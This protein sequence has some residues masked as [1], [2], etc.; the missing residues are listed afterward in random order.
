MKHTWKRLLSVLLALVMVIGLIAVPAMADEETGKKPSF[1]WEEVENARRL[2]PYRTE[3]KPA[4]EPLY[5]DSDVV[6]VSIVFDEKPAI[7]VFSTKEI[8]EDEAAM[9]YSDGLRAKQESMVE[10][11]SRKALKGQELDVVWNL[12]LIA[13]LV[14][15]N[16]PYG[17][18]DAIKSVEGV[19]DVYIETRYE[20]ATAETADEPNQSIAT[21][22]TGATEVWSDYTG[23]GS[24]IAI[25]DTGLDTDHEL[26]DPNAFIKA[27]SEK[28]DVDLLT[29]GE[30]SS[31]WSRLH[32]A[33]RSSGRGAQ[34]Y[35]NTKV[36]FGFNYVDSDFDITHDNDSAGEHGSHVAGIAAA[37]R[38]VKVSGKYVSAVEN[39]LTQGVAPDAQLLIMKVFGKGGGAYDSDYMVAIEDAIVLGADSVNLSLG[40]GAPGFATSSTPAYQEIMDNLATCD[41]TVTISMGNSGSWA[42]S[43]Y[44]EVPYAGDGNFYTGGSPGSYAN[45]FTVASVDNIGQTGPTLEASGTKFAYYESDGYGNELIATI[46][47]EHDFIYIDSAGT[48]NEFA[49]AAAAGL[50]SGKI[51]VCNRGGDISFYVKANA[52]AANGAAAVIVA[53]NQDG[54]IHMN[55]TGYEYTIPAITITQAD[56]ALLKEGESGTLTIGEGDEAYEVTYY[57]GKITVCDGVSAIV[58]DPGYYTMSDFSSWGVPGNLT[59]KPEITAPGGSIYSVNGA[60]AGGK[61]YEIMS[62]TSM[63]A[64]QVTGLAALVA[65]YIRENNLTSKTGKSERFLVQSLLMS[66]AEPLFDSEDNYYSV[67]KQGSGLARVDR[68]VTARSYIEMD[69]DA[70]ASAAD[71]KVKVELGD[72]PDR[73]GT[74]SFKFTINNFSNED[75]TYDLSADFFTQYVYGGRFVL[76]DTVIIPVEIEYKID[77]EV[78]SRDAY[79]DFLWDF[80]GDDEISALDAQVILDYVVKGTDIPNHADSADVDEDGKITT[81]DAY[82]V[83]SYVGGADLT[84]PAGGKKEVEV[85]FWIIDTFDYNGSFIEGYVYA[86][87]QPTASEKEEGIEATEVHSIPVLGYYGSWMEPRMLELDNN[88]YYI[89]VGQR[90][91]SIGY[92]ND[93]YAKLPGGD[94][95]TV[96]GN[97]FVEDD[98]Y[99]PERDSVSS[100]SVISSVQYTAI[101]NYGQSRLTIAQNGTTK[102]DAQLGSGYGAYYYVNGGSWQNRSTAK[103]INYSLANFAED[104]QLVLTFAIAPE[105]YV[106]GGAVD[107]DAI[108]EAAASAACYMVA[109]VATVDNT[110]PVINGEQI[111]PVYGTDSDALAG[112]SIPVSDNRYV[113]AVV[114]C[115]EAYYNGDEEG[116]FARTGSDADAELGAESAFDFEVDSES[117][118]FFIQAYD[119][120][121]NMTTY[122]L[123]LNWEE[124]QD[125]EIS[126]TL[127]EIEAAIINYGEVQLTAEVAPWGIDESVTWT[128]SNSGV[129]VD[130]TGLVKNVSAKDGETAT[131]TATSVADPTKSATCTVSIVFLHKNLN[132]VVWDED[133]DVWFAK[134]DVGAL[135][136]YEKL[137]AS[138]AKL[139]I[140]AAAYDS[141]DVLYAASF[142]TSDWSSV[143]YTVNERTWELTQVGA[144]EYGF[145]DLCA[146]PSLG[147]N[148]ML[149]IYGTYV[150]VIDKTSA[151]ILGVFDYSEYTSGSYFVGLAYY[152]QYPH[153]TYGNIDVAFLLD[154]NGTLY[155]DAF[156]LYEGK[157]YNFGGGKNPI[158][159][160]GEAVDINYWQS[161]YFDGESLYWNRFNDADNKVEVICV[162]EGNYN[163]GAFADGVWPVAATYESGKN[164]TKTTPASPSM[165]IDSDKMA[166]AM[167]A[168]SVEK[169]DFIKA[170]T[171]KLNG[172]EIETREVA[173]DAASETVTIKVTADEASNNGL[174]VVN[175]DENLTYVADSVAAKVDLSSIKV[176]EENRT[177]TV[178]YATLDEVAKDAVVATLKFTRNTENEATVTVTTKEINETYE[179]ADPVEITLETV[180]VT[181]VTISTESLSVYVG[182]SANLTATVEPEDAMNKAVV[183]SSDY[184]SIASV[185]ENGKVTGVAAGTATIT[186]TTVDGGYTATCSVTVSVKPVTPPTPTPVPTDPTEPT[187]PDDPDDPENPDDGKKKFIDVT[188]ESAYYYTPVYWAVDKG[189]TKGKTADTFDPN[190]DCTRAQIVTFLY[191]AMGEP[192]VDTTENPFTDVKAGSYYEKAV[193][194]ALANGVTKG[195]SSTTFS[196]DANCTR[197]QIVTF[198]Y[199]ALGEPEVDTAEN[200]FTD[201][202]AGSYYE[203]AVLWAVAN[204][205][206]KGKTT[207]TFDPTGICTRGQ[208]VT[209]LYRALAE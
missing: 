22:M 59:L 89:Q 164:P 10:A 108:A 159:T 128:S 130:A 122:K 196:P 91:T 5:K 135:P 42:D 182:D 155:K 94:E 167:P 112:L 67:M 205:V 107:W 132:G 40:S 11:I 142:D 68:A 75:V 28:G 125:D 2:L 149:A 99:M 31:A 98:D 166:A 119:Y 176:D 9:A 143:L 162:G 208:A 73:N 192:E 131:I 180:A 36:P 72:D 69:A 148:T 8:A 200:P 92:G 83:L 74:Y 185:D 123:N 88:P 62:G 158:G 19:K 35:V 101:R 95:V 61:G 168:E 178:G 191:R 7:K 51:A 100:A 153:Q 163:L 170:P 169:I 34:A 146:A 140:S 156:A 179:A 3:E 120:A 78:F 54:I 84:V 209:F 197:A 50:V 13:N 206:T 189:I 63:A 45:A 199:R 77:G 1:T 114:I 177:I 165:V 198:L 16:V 87:A 93:F 184:E 116:F 90:Y 194:W 6:R 24:L 139:A 33:E 157:Y 186:V 97:P 174:I 203:K 41:T 55:L 44:Y 15:A 175:Y 115:D 26:F 48:K 161:L 195:T 76:E 183:W 121:G 133:G 172:A 110:A 124:E 111:A 53:N 57:T 144:S 152:S 14:S 109:N 201:V 150:F 118:H 38:Y 127:S 171:G 71:G 104:D 49:A 64:P 105:Y 187:E 30:V 56:A 117:A 21:G 193:L 113:A 65:Q 80:N 190:G 27:V 154:A 25:I 102:V 188:D 204:G 106:E 141:N 145:M 137:N 39:V 52:A 160:I 138:S 202:K 136:E 46:A 85:S 173:D 129:T 82:V 66:T 96:A 79:T 17:A 86:T 181:G 151:D 43:T 23:A 147:S 37:N 58:T 29:K 60:E 134:Y 20:P 70:T 32:A 81:H 18:I 12:T 207:T 126:V 4:E 103:T 47:G